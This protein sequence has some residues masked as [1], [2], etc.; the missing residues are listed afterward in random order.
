MTKTT[1]FEI[2]KKLAEIGFKKETDYFFYLT[3][4]DWYNKAW[5]W[6]YVWHYATEGWDDANNDSNFLPSYDLETLID[7][8]PKNISEMGYVYPT[9]YHLNINLSQ[10]STISYIEDDLHSL[11]DNHPVFVE[12]RENESLADTAGRLLILLHE[13]NLIKF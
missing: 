10:L 6:Q 9:G 13:K 2:S 4:P 5:S 7:A 3:K 1:N 11:R 12:K 8:L